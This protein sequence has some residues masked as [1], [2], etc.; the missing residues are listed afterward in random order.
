MR[1]QLRK[2]TSFSRPGLRACALGAGV[3]LIGLG[4]GLASTSAGSAVAPLGPVFAQSIE[5]I[6]LAGHVSFTAPGMSPAPLLVAQQLPVGS[7][8]DASGG[9]V[10]LIAADPSG[11]THSGEFYRGAFTINQPSAE[12][13]VVE[14][15]LAGP[16]LACGGAST[17]KAPGGR[18]VW[19]K[20]DP[21][22]SSNGYSARTRP[23]P[24]K[25][26][27]Q[28]AAASV[29]TWNTADA[30]VS[31]QP[32]TAVVVTQG[33]V[34]VT[35]P[36]SHKPVRQAPIVRAGGSIGCYTGRFTTR[37]RYSTATVRGSTDVHASRVGAVISLHVNSSCGFRVTGVSAQVVR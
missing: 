23:R 20:A 14:L 22:Y 33:A 5:A 27:A 4:V 37:G 17:A 13:G 35:N 7:I 8:V 29:T 15:R 16:A 6:P 24:P 19:G 28:D 3:S 9:R 30:C 18:N 12:A 32:T 36:I 26:Y 1:K 25:H 2:Y 21:S 34:A 11:A 31:G 10:R